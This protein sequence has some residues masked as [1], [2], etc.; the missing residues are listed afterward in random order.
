MLIVSL[1]ILTLMTIMAVAFVTLMK[2]EFAATTN[3][4]DGLRAKMA[5]DSGMTRVLIN[6]REN[7]DKPLFDG[8]QLASHVF[9]AQGKTI[10]VTL[11][12]EEVTHANNPFFYGYLGRT[13]RG[14]NLDWSNANTIRG[15]DEYKVKVLET[16]ALFDLNFPVEFEDNGVPKEGETFILMLK[17]LGQ[18]IARRPG[19]SED[20]ISLARF[21]APSG[22]NFSGA[23]AIA[24]F[25]RTQDGEQ[26]SSKSQ[27]RDLFAPDNQ[28]D[29]AFNMLQDFVTMHA[30]RDHAAVMPSAEEIEHHKVI[31]VDRGRAQINLNLAPKE[32][33]VA[34]VAPLA[35][36]RYALMPSGTAVDIESGSD[37]AETSYFG[38]GGR[39]SD[40]HLKE[41]TAFEVREGWVY[42]GPIG[43]DRAEKV[44]DWIIDNRPFVSLAHFYDRLRVE[45]N[46]PAGQ[47][48]LDGAL[49]QANPSDTRLQ[50]P[51]GSRVNLT[52][53]E[54]QPW[55][56]Q[57]V[58]EAA[59]SLLLANFNP[60]F[61]SNST[62]PA[63]AAYVPIDKANLVYPLDPNNTNTRLRSRQTFDACF[64][65]RGIYEITSLGQLRDAEGS[66]VSKEKMRTIVRT[67][68][69]EVHRS[70]AA[71]EENDLTYG[72]GTAGKPE[73]FG[74][75]TGPETRFF[76]TGN[77]TAQKTDAPHDL[78]NRSFGHLQLEPRAAYYD[79]D[80]ADPPGDF[81]FAGFGQGLMGIY[82]EGFRKGE[83]PAY[84]L[85]ANSTRE[86]GA[87]LRLSDPRSPSVLQKARGRAARKSLGYAPLNTPANNWYVTRGT[88][89]LFRDGFYA[90]YRRERDQTLWYRA[91]A[92]EP[93]HDLDTAQ[94]ALGE[95]TGAPAGGS[96]REGNLWYRQGGFEFWYKPDFDWSLSDASGAL[97]AYPMACGYV[98]ASR[99]Y[100]N[101]GNPA[102]SAPLSDSPT[103]GTQIVFERN[104]QGQLR[105]SR[106]YFRVVGSYKNGADL[107]GEKPNRFIDPVAGDE[108]GGD[109]GFFTKDDAYAYPPSP[110]AKGG[111]ID[112]Y[113]EAAE[114][115]PV[116]P[117]DPDK[118]YPWPP[119]EMKEDV[120]I[121]RART[122]AY[123]SYDD[124]KEWRRGEW[125]HIAVKWNDAKDGDEALSIYVDGKRQSTSHGMPQDASTPKNKGQFVR[126]NEPPVYT[127][128]EGEHRHPRDHLFVGGIERRL[129]IGGSGVFK[130]PNRMPVRGNN[131]VTGGVEENVIRL[132][133]GGTVDD[134]ITWD[135]NGGGGDNLRDSPRRF[136]TEGVFVQHFDLGSKFPGG[137][138]PIQ[139]ARL[140]VHTL[141]PSHHG[142]RDMTTAGTVTV[143]VD[144]PAGVMM[145]DGASYQIVRSTDPVNNPTR[146]HVN[147]VGADGRP[148]FVVPP[149]DPA[150]EKPRLRYQLEFRPAS[151]GAAGTRFPGLTAVDTPVVQEVSL[152]WFL[153]NEEVLLRE[154][155]ID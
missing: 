124:L 117:T 63:Q 62:N 18:A 26:Y 11:P 130:H 149:G 139:L 126:L 60:A 98:F 17:A 20:P 106:L 105:A 70:Q 48:S 94:G 72:G 42:V 138:Q 15:L 23:D 39:R 119:A 152:S 19:Y 79:G 28:G 145:Q 71:F 31:T 83:N 81:G 89:T 56:P 122:D 12:V 110:G 9:G 116:G 40:W 78:A 143:R 86:G 10:D 74:M 58:K 35:G 109:D 32:V 8:D 37:A 148:A 77:D 41:D 36:R 128:E 22:Q 142:R 68:D 54:T 34:A 21:T 65:S 141:F 50:T 99:V 57:F 114:R 46:K 121:K 29:A 100:Y 102:E 14:E 69:M 76:F 43:I 101:P 53:I 61:I 129:A 30:W 87:D 47:G 16:S 2:T 125:H 33:L 90:H 95:G 64:E 67:F 82:F 93:E 7:L 80:P 88:G 45:M 1:G 111:A 113:R 92:G 132:Y 153:P 140:T 133:A 96:A 123:V 147:L 135:G 137:N 3:Y 91:G 104:T 73:R 84:Y 24:A 136:E 85:N 115:K 144:E 103:D 6:L 107:G 131:L 25:R 75:D 120:G 146:M 134:F 108:F 150:A 59:Y 112:Y 27:L 155:V 151:F 51:T 4:V 66:I 127:D 44:A 118:D 97:Y 49:P 154:R 13:Y 5:A 52:G 55:W 38:D